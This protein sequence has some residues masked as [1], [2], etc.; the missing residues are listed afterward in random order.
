MSIYMCDMDNYNDRQMILLFM[1]V[2][3]AEAHVYK[4]LS[5]REV[6]SL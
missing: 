4:D 1:I 3:P 6:A 5:M 2:S